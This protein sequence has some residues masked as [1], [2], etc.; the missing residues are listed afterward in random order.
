MD[1]GASPRVTAESEESE[2]SLRINI[3]IQIIKHS[4]NGNLKPLEKRQNLGSK[5]PT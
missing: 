4:P 5:F 1:P 2:E 3:R